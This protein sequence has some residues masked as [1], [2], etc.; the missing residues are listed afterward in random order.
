MIHQGEGAGN[1]ARH[2]QKETA[3]IQQSGRRLAL[4][5][6]GAAP[7]MMVIQ[8]TAGGRRGEVKGIVRISNLDAAQVERGDAH[9]IRVRVR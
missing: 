2:T 5:S 7:G 4:L 8:V 1:M 9:G 3:M 6:T